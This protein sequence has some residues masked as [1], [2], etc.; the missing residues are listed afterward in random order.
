MLPIE[1]QSRLEGTSHLHIQGQRISQAR[2]QHVS[3]APRFMLISCSAYPSALK[4]E[5]SRSS[6]TSV[7]FR[8]TTR[9]IPE[10]R[11]LHVPCCESLKHYVDSKV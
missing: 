5:V 9:H 11:T 1:I 2:N 10:D 8:R 6:E 7:D 4:M 3:L